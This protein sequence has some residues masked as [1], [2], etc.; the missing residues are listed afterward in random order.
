[1]RETTKTYVEYLYPGSFFSEEESKPVKERDPE[2]ILKTLPKG[3]FAFLFYDQASTM[4]KVDGEA[5]TVYGKRK[6]VSGKYYPDAEIYTVPQLKALDEKQYHILIANME[7]NGWKRVVKTRR[8]NFQPL[9]KSDTI[10]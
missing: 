6:N 3:V 9:E 1:M 10:L 2:K 5:Q 4:V 8:G 7:G